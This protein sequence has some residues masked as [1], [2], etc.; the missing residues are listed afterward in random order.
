MAD[1][2]AWDLGARLLQTPSPEQLYQRNAPYV[3]NGATQFTTPLSPNDEVLFQN[4]RRSNGVPF[5]SGANSDYDMRG[6]WNAL[7]T[8]DPRART[9]I[10]PND[11]LMHFPD[12]WKTPYHQSFSNESMYANQNAPQWINDSQLASPS[13]RLFYDEKRGY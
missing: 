6:F 1:F 7:T 9:A 2:D 8:M 13:G 11:N 10:N 5:N 4:W 12:T 3:A